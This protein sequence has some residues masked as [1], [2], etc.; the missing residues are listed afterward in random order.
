MITTTG[1]R[2]GRL[3]AAAMLVMTLGACGNNN[4]APQPAAGAGGAGPGAGAA[5]RPSAMCTGNPDYIITVHFSSTSPHCPMYVGPAVPQSGAAECASKKPNCIRKETGGGP[6]KIYWQSDPAGMSFG[7]YFDPF[8]GPSHDTT[9][10]CVKT[11]I[12]GGGGPKG[13]PPVLAG[14]EVM[15]KYTIATLAGTPAQPTV[16]CAPLDPPLIIEH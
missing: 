12:A 3:L 2:W 16:D 1:R 6:T 10:G 15:Y 8:V 9:N 11:T 5:P 14:E 7:V 13:I 4:G